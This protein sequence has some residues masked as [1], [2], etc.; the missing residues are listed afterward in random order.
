M[1]HPISIQRAKRIAAFLFLSVAGALAAEENPYRYWPSYQKV[2]L[3][4]YAEPT[5]TPHN[6]IATG[7]DFSLPPSVTVSPRSY[8]VF[9]RI[10]NLSKEPKLP[11]VR[12]KANPVLSIWVEWK[13]LEPERDRYDFERLKSFIG[14]AAAAG[15]GVEIRPITAIAAR[16]G[17]RTRGSVPGYVTALGTPIL[18]DPPKKGD[19]ISHYDPSHP[20]FHRRYM[21]LVQ[22]F[23]KSG[24]P[25]NPTVK[26]IVVGYSSE[27]YGDEGIG[28]CS[29]Q[30]VMERL[31]AWAHACQGVAGKVMM[32]GKSEYGFSKG[33]GFRDGMV[34]VYMYQIPDA[35]NGQFI[36]E[37]GYLTTDEK[38]PIIAK[39][40]L[41]GDENETYEEKMSFR[42]GPTTL[43]PYR[44]FSST[45]RAIQ[46]RKNIILLND[47]SPIP[48]LTAYLS[49]EMGR[50]VKD[51]PDVWCFLR[52]NQMQPWSYNGRAKKMGYYGDFSTSG[53]VPCKNFERWLYQRDS[54]GYETQ[55]V[56]PIPTSPNHWMMAP[57]HDKDLIARA[58]TRIGFAVDDRFLPET[59][60][61][62]TF[63]ITFHDGVRGTMNLVYEG[64][65]GRVQYPI[66]ATGN[67][68][69]RTATV[70]TTVLF[71]AKGLAYDFEIHSPEKVPVSIVRVIRSP[72][73]AKP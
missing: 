46:L 7:W 62:V 19:G 20:D 12:I 23:G 61:S 60:Q 1:H 57:G 4:D 40:G 5:W 48:D 44:Y 14:L 10:F 73:K 68:V 33:F 31:D 50:T 38:A 22:A 21:K 54:E 26:S 16:N 6:T 51:T 47:F 70:H 72:E 35:A 53:P 28:D 8:L 56:L 67:D 17:D 30:H 39:G 24:I 34:E 43:F 9:A 69:I 65:S 15:Y 32:C 41:N 49:L 42:F 66:I 64:A 2:P 18:N 45:L 55:A 52:E 63:K 29:K 25:T 3:T 11:P 37:N 27:T 59:P 58:G 36:D 71:K 13:E